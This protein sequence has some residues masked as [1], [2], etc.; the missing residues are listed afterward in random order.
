MENL[1][2]SAKK[3]TQKYNCITVLKN[4][5]T[6]ICN[7]DLEIYINQHGNSALAKAGTGDV[8]AGIISGLIAQK[9]EPFKAAKLGVLIHSLAGEYASN[10]LTEYSVLASD[11]LKYI[12]NAI[13]E[14]I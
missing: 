9:V 14:L 5:R 3:I 10:D 2:N 12:S 7:T 11:L 8:L 6:I 1:E 13:K 4:H